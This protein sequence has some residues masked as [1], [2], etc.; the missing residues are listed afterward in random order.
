M[1]TQLNTQ[2]VSTGA[3]FG[4]VLGTLASNPKQAQRGALWGAV[5]GV[6]LALLLVRRSQAAQEAQA[7]ALSGYGMD[8]G[9]G[10]NILPCVRRGDRGKGVEWLH[11]LLA[12]RGFGVVRNGL[13]QGWPDFGADTYAQVKAFQRSKGL[14]V[15]GIVGPNTWKKL[16]P[17][18]TGLPCR[19]TRRAAPAPQRPAPQTVGPQAPVG[20]PAGIPRAAPPA[21][22]PE[23]EG[24]FEKNKTPIIV[25]SSVL[26]VA[27]LSLV[28]FKAAS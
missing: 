5:L 14:G 7:E 22:L 21:P 23:E 8:V 12:G 26:G 16:S 27:L 15:D 13:S 20:P 24:F 4:A 1:R 10:E 28:A 2:A 17:R 3:I 6:P 25:A 19:S 18:V 9:H 11:L